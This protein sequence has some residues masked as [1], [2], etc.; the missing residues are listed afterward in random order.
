[1]KLTDYITSFLVDQGIDNI[2]GVTGGGVVHLFDSISKTENISAVYCHH[3]QAAALA[4]V[5]YAK[6]NNNIGAAIVTTGPGCTNAITGVL[7]AWQDSIPC[8]FISGQARKEHTSHGTK[9]RQLG[10]QE[11]DILPVVQPITKYVVMVD[12]PENI[13]YILEK[14]IYLAF[15]GRPGPVWIDLP[16]DF[17][18]TDIDINTLTSFKIPDKVENH[19]D[20][21]T[22]ESID[23]CLSLL[24]DSKRPLFFAGNGIHL[25]HAEDKFKEIIDQLNIPFVSTW[26]ASDI[27]PDE[28]NLNIGRV[29][30]SG[31]RGANIAVQNCDLLICIGSHLGI[32]HTGTM[33]SSFAKNAKIIMV[34]IDEN[35]LSNETVHVDFPILSDSKLFLDGLLSCINNF[36]INNIDSWRKSCNNFRKYNEVPCNVDSNSGFIN[37]YIF[38]NKLSTEMM[39]G[40]IVVVDGGGTNLYMSFQGIKLKNNQRIICSSAI[41]AMGT[42]FPESIG[43]SFASPNCK[44]ICLIGDGSFQLNVQEL[45][46]IQHHNL[47]IKIFVM[48]NDGYLAIRHTQEIFLDSNFTGSAKEGGMSLPDSTLIAEAY[49]IKTT[50]ID[51]YSDLQ[52]KIQW[53]LDYPGP[54]LCEIKISPKQKLIPQQG[55]DKNSDGTFSARPLEDMYPFLPRLEFNDIM[56]TE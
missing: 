2:F 42:G 40:D 39:D 15:D 24:A 14:A 48:N 12:D 36:N 30:I 34:D 16:L 38:L 7:A 25:G 35:E 44:V 6:V 13:R 27:I 5:A 53:T 54:S 47:P 18:W 21:L 4:A 55:W 23:L 45:Q 52:K 32:T 26:T 3:E 29:G 10:T 31:Q 37:P 22:H 11:M 20:K 28:N 51:N 9:L 1:M 33:F 19:F 41:S 17:Q 8:I 43:A 49:G 50:T 56:I 46:T